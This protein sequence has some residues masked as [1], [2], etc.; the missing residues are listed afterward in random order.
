MDL[1]LSDEQTLLQ[2]TAREFVNKNSSLRRIRA[3]RDNGDALGY[4]RDLW[5]EMAQLGWLGIPFPEAYGGVGLGYTDLMVVLEEAGRG[6][7]PEPL[8]SAISLGGSA[9]ALGGTPQQQQAMLPGLIAGN[10]LVTVAYQESRSRY[11]PTVVE[12]RAERAGNGWTLRGEKIQVPDLFGSDRV[13][14]SAR[15]AGG[16]ADAHGITLFVL[17]GQAPGVGIERQW[18]IDSRNAGCLRLDQVT[19]GP[20]HVVGEVDEGISLLGAV[21]DRATAG[22][23]AEMLGSMQA[24]FD[25]TLEYLK[26]RVQ[27]GVPIGSFQALKHRAAKMFIETE[28]SR[29]V[30]LAAHKAIDEGSPEAPKLVSA[31]KTRC[32]DALVLIGNEM[33]QMHGGIGMTDEH[34]T[35]FFLKRARVAEMTFGDGQ[36]HRD[37]FAALNGY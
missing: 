30:V 14:V 19:V 15:T 1:V 23:C 25:M 8:L 29:S 34:D 32:S 21:L 35:G 7:L 22:L 9:L 5:G 20:E 27:F 33:V 16:V 36:Y 18:R 2:E 26:T 13:I 11:S 4:S 28:L 12:T 31:A 37:R 10:L 6:L 24:A 3:L 17:E